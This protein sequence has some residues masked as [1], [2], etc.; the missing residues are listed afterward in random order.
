VTAWLT[1]G[2]R[3]IAQWRTAGEARQQD[4][5]VRL[6]VSGDL[7]TADAMTATAAVLEV[8][9]VIWSSRA[10][11]PN[12]LRQILDRYPGCAVAA[13]RG[14]GCYL[15]AGRFQQNKCRLRV[16]VSP[17]A[18]AAVVCA[19]FVHA[20]LAA[21]WPLA[22]LDPARLELLAGLGPATAAPIPFALY[23][24]PRLGGEP[25]EFAPDVVG[26]GRAALGVDDQC[27]GEMFT[28]S[29]GLI[30]DQ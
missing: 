9:D 22:A 14:R 18:S 16:P 1:A 13:A 6:A 11:P 23:F 19:I 2:D 29:L 24:S 27:A 26:F 25:I 10:Q 5:C 20:W 4:A 12:W 3:T 15:V 30:Q 28:R 21:G 17:S 8:A 7:M